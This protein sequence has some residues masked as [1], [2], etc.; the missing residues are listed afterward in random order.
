MFQFERV[1][2]TFFEAYQTAR[3]IV[4][5]RARADK[6]ADAGLTGIDTS[7]YPLYLNFP[8]PLPWKSWLGKMGRSR[9]PWAAGPCLNEFVAFWHLCAGR[10]SRHPSAGKPI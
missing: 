6:R 7:P 9:R 3:S 10:Q 1:R 8:L 2:R 4:D 5:I